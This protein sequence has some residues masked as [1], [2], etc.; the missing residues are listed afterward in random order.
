M[1]SNITAKHIFLTI[2]LAAVMAGIFYFIFPMLTRTKYLGAEHVQDITNA[3]TTKDPVAVV[4]PAPVDPA[5]PPPTTHVAT[6]AQVKAVYMSSWVAG[7]KSFLAKVMKLVDETEVNAVVIDVKDSTGKISFEVYDPKLKAEGA[8][9]HRIADL[10]GLISE[11]HTRGV[12]VIARIAVFQDPYFVK[13][14]PE[15]GVKK[16]SDKNALWGDRKGM[17]WLDAGS[18]DVW[19]YTVA[20]GREAYAQGFDELNFDYIRF[21]SDGNMKDIWYPLSEG[22]DK[23]AVMAS[24]FEYMHGQFPSDTPAISADLFGMTTTNTDDL[25]IGQVLETALRNFDY[26]APMVYPSH[27]PPNWNGYKNPATKPYEVI[28]AS[29]AGAVA[30]AKAIGE[31]PLKLRPWLQDFD[32][33]AKYTAEMIRAQIKATYDVGLD[34]WMMWDPANTYTAGGYEKN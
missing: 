29:M 9:E 8:V 3:V 16:A 4:P 20:I 14:H 11:L 18:K 21:P 25:G 28:H 24:F 34:S 12:Y 15:F 27:Y 10:P 6:P 19:D 33:G 17:H 13:K 7:S 26:V 23:P 1:T 5:V 22:K 32:M 30:K 31:N 2:G